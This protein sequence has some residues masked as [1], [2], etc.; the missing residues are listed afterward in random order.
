MVT[1]N[2][3]SFVVDR[4][5]TIRWKILSAGH[6]FYRFEGQAEKEDWAGQEV[7]KFAPVE[8]REVFIRAKGPDPVPLKIYLAP[9]KR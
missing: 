2:G 9:V 6:I 4:N 8:P 3:T 5:M 1:T 7:F